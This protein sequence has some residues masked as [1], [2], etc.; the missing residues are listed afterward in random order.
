MH[1]EVFGGRHRLQIMR[2]VALHAPDESNRHLTRKIGVF[3]VRLLTAS[4]SRIAKDIDVGGPE[5]QSEI[6]A[7]V[8]MTNGV[9]ILG[10]RLGRNGIGDPMHQGCIPRRSQTN[11]LRKHRSQAS[12]RHAVQSLVP[13]AIGGNAQAR[14]RRRQVLHLL[15][16]LLQR[17]PRHQI[18]R[19]LLGRQIGILVGRSRS[20][21]LCVHQTGE[22]KKQKAQREQKL[23]PNHR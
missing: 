14:D 5:G 4:P 17:H 2:V 22:Q 1:V 9:V 10:S 16:L 19:A 23:F 11:C 21:L 18:S 12:P 6:A 20:R 15:R 7:V 13:P 3:P 8:V